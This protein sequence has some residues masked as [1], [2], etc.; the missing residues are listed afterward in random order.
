MEDSA[1]LTL[2]EKIVEF[3]GYSQAALEKAAALV[4]D[5]EKKASALT[6]CRKKAV[7]AMIEH[8]RVRPDQRAKLA[9]A[10]QDPVRA[11]E[12]LAKVAGH[13]N[14]EELAHLG[15]GVDGNGRVKA[16]AHADPSR[17]LNSPFVGART[18]MIKQSDINLFSRLG[19]PI[20][21]AD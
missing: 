10:L 15:N 19:L 11:L 8:E 2:P 9:E 1:T 16:A 13:R 20:P 14:R 21:S 17:S 6:E 7:E 4:A 18:T 12:L 3:I 5:H